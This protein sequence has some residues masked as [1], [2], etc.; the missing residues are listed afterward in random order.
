[1]AI[2]LESWEFKWGIIE[3]ATCLDLIMA[4]QD[5]GVQYEIHK[6]RNTISSDSRA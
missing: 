2:E 4:D 3:P 6:K 5:P 1:M